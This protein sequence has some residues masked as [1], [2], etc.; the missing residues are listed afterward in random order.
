MLKTGM[1]VTVGTAEIN[2]ALMLEFIAN[3]CVRKNPYVL[4]KLDQ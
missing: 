4:S 2:N 1:L 3:H